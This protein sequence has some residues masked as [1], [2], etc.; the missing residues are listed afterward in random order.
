MSNF[1]KGLAVIG[2]V[3]GVLVLLGFYWMSC[4]R[5][6]VQLRNQIEAQQDVNKASHDTMWKILKDKAGVT[7][8]YKDAFAKIYPD[9]IKGRYQDRQN[10]L[11]QF[12]KEANPNFDTSLYKDLMGSIEAE[13]KHFLR[14][15]KKLRDL[16]RQH[17]TLLDQPPSSW[18]L[19]SKS[20]ID[21][22]IVTSTN[23]EEV[24]E[25]GKDDQT[26]FNK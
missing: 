14:E 18:F 1:G 7:N 4:A 5:S 13:R 25:T 2:V 24:F 23:T 19:A 20:H 15:Q 11:V 26:L 3:F 22:T 8:E 16:K 6:E 17:D 10:L 9:L 12:V 21:V